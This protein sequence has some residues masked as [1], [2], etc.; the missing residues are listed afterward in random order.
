M[1]YKKNIQTSRKYPLY[2]ISDINQF[3]ENY[4]TH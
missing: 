3:S 1:N 4:V 2:F